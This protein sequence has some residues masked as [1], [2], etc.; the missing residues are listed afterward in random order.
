MYVYVDPTPTGESVTSA[1]GSS[2]TH[3][4]VFFERDESVAVLPTS[5]IIREKHTDKTCTVKWFNGKW[6]GDIL[7]EGKKPVYIVFRPCQLD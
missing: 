6:R 4:L 2:A 7:F 5:R 1:T 3:V